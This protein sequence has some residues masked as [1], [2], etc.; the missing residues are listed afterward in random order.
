M[1]PDYNGLHVVTACTINSVSF[2][3]T[4]T[5]VQTSIGVIKGSVF[6][7]LV[8][9]PIGTKITLVRKIGKLWNADTALSQTE[10]IVANFI[11]AKEVSLP[12]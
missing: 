9:P 8:A 3:S 11:R 4:I 7:L 10:N 6:E 2:A 1:T 12:Q 5:G